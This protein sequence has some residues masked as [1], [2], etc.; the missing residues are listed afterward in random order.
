MRKPRNVGIWP[1]FAFVV[2]LAVSAAQQQHATPQ[3]AKPQHDDS[4]SNADNAKKKEDTQVQNDKTQP[5][6]TQEDAESNSVDPSQYVGT[7]ACKGCHESAGGSFDSNPHSKTLSE[8]R[9][10]RQ[11]CE[12]CHG[13]GQS[14]SESGDPDN[15]VRFESMSK[16]GTSKI[17]SQCHL[18]S[19]GH[20]SPI[21][22]QHGKAD[23]GCLDCHSVHSAN[24]Q[25]HLLKSEQTKLC[26]TC[27][28]SKQE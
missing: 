1:G 26:S 7:E 5:S 28:V 17:C 23:V 27:H 10:D 15:I 3:H 2:L 8:K 12:S 4:K 22:L 13:P 11:G 14:H 9:P 18:F 16:T 21:H 19:K 20:G 6:S 24:V 25:K